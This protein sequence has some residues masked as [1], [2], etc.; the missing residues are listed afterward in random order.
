MLLQL[1]LGLRRF[2]IDGVLQR[3]NRWML[4][5][6]LLGLRRFSGDGVLQRQN[7]RLLQLLGLRR[8]SG[9]GVL[10]RQNRWV[11]LRLLYYIRPYVPFALPCCEFE[12]HRIVLRLNFLLF[13]QIHNRAERGSG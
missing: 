3:Q 12:E 4:L 2:S 10:Q 11:L 13:D 8:F 9:D 1:L 6:L 7:R 5:Q